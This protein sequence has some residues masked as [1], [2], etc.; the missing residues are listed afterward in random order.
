MATHTDHALAALD[1]LG[2]VLNKLNE[3]DG[4]WA[5]DVEGSVWHNAEAAFRGALALVVGPS[6]AISVWQMW[7]D[8]NTT[9]ASELVAEFERAQRE[10]VR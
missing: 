9:P 10:D 5:H 6:A 3:A 4:L 8:N 2:D 1:A 7:M